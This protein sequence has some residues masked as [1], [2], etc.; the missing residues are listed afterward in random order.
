[1]TQE[2]IDAANAVVAAFSTGEKHDTLPGIIARLRPFLR[3]AIGQDAPKPNDS[4][5]QDYMVSLVVYDAARE[6]I[7]E[8]DPD[9]VNGFH[10]VFSCV[11]EALEALHEDEAT[12][13][14]LDAAGASVAALS[15]RERTL[16]STLSRN[17]RGGKDYAIL[18]HFYVL[19]GQDY[20]V[21]VRVSRVAD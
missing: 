4:R 18:R 13:D 3:E 9:K 10:G 8:M 11:R 12:G 15:A 7:G 21:D 20:A 16:R 19:D 6:P 5:S 17:K 1:M 2:R 14:D